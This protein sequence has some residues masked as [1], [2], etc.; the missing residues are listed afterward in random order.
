MELKCCLLKSLCGLASVG[1]CTNTFCAD[2][3]Q[4][5]PYVW[6]TE[7]LSKKEK[8]Q[9]KH[10]YF[11]TAP[12][13]L[14]S[15]W[16]S[17]SFRKSMSLDEMIPTSLPPILPLSVMGMPQKP[18]RALAWKTSRTRSLG[19][20]TTGSVMKPCSYRWRE[21]GRE[22][23]KRKDVGKDKNHAGLLDLTTTQTD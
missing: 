11:Q 23:R 21:E 3:Q 18:W 4:P 2:F 1:K 15:R 14:S 8:K 17:S 10:F 22:V 16:W 5:C 20:I 9:T 7:A 13:S 12:T 6:C 19:L